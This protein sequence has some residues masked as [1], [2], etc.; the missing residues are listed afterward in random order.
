VEPQHPRSLAVGPSGGQLFVRLY[1]GLSSLAFANTTD[2]YD[3]NVA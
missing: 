1:H 3:L 2:K